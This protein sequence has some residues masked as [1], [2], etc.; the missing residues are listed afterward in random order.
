MPYQLYN[1]RSEPCIFASPTRFAC[2]VA[3]AN[4][5]PRYRVLSKL[6]AGAFSTAA[7]LPLWREGP[8]GGGCWG[9]DGFAFCSLLQV[10]LCADEKDSEGR[11]LAMKAYKSPTTKFKGTSPLLFLPL[12][13]PEVCKSKKS[14]TEQALSGCLLFALPFPCFKWALEDFRKSCS[15][16]KG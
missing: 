16:H 2:G 14:V 8:C 5:H 6:G 10:W 7:T 1:A 9:P 13:V 15:K 4:A 3:T 11:L 12:G